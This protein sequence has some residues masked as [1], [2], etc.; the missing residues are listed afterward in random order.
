VKVL[1]ALTNRGTE[2]CGNLER[3]EYE[4]CIA[5]E[6]VHHSRTKTKSPQTNN[7]VER[8]RLRR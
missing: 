3:H 4:L 1:R 8:W 6:D 7:I 2:Y 5:V